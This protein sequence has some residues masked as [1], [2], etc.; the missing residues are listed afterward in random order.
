MD[1]F[2]F[3]N[4]VRLCNFL[5]LISAVI[6]ARPGLTHEM[7]TP[8]HHPVTTLNSEAQNAF[9]RG[10]LLYYAFNGTEAVGAFQNA[11]RVD[12]HLAMA[13]WGQA[14]AHGSN[15]NSPVNEARYNLAQ[16]AMAM[17]LQLEHYA[18]PV[19]KLYIEALAKRYAT[20]WS[21]HDQGEAAFLNAMEL[22]TQRYPADDDAICIWAEA[23]MEKVVWQSD[24]SHLSAWEAGP[25][26]L[27]IPEIAIAAQKLNA[28][29][30]RNPTHVMANHLIIHLY[31]FSNIRGPAF[32]AS[33]RLLAMSLEPAAEHLIHMPAH[34]FM[35]TGNY[36]LALKVS[37]RV[38]PMIENYLH[39]PG[40][41]PGHE[42]YLSHDLNVGFAAAMM[43]GNYQNANR[44]AERLDR[45]YH[46]DDGYLAA[47]RFYRWGA[48]RSLTT[49]PPSDSLRLVQ[50]YERVQNQDPIAARNFLNGITQ[51]QSS[52]YHLILA[53]IA[54]KSNAPADA[55][56][57]FKIAFDLENQKSFGE[58]IPLFPV[59]ESYAAALFHIGDFTNAEI[60]WRKTL[61][62]YPNDPR[63]LF[64][65]S[66]TLA[67]LGHIQA[68]QKIR[69]QFQFFWRDSDTTLDM[70]L[71]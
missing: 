24:P 47:A 16:G 5:C 36:A 68:A 37:D 2:C 34:T 71:L 53:K 26:L 22:L 64:G 49:F 40:I 44:Y 48:I 9:D 42:Y 70:H 33:R 67:R 62:K 18:I 7:R 19:E 15:F 45:Y 3:K 55:M 4:V 50:A 10:L 32:A 1:A 35:D 56:Q 43:L 8:V 27:G 13:Y 39:R 21:E 61:Q 69:A 41:A 58:Q 57:E 51:P 14:L 54:M 52:F 63:A 38:V 17:A 46:S 31:E 66:E 29:I 60:I 30:A 25:G 28:V 6:N 23:L 65:L 12:S 11:L 20:P 59:G